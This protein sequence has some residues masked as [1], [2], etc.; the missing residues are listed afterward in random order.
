MSN[1]LNKKRNFAD[2][3]VITG[4]TYAGIQALPYVTAAVKSPD[5]VAKNYIRTIDGLTKS[6]VVNN[7][8]TTASGG[9]GIIQPGGT[10][11]AC[12]FNAGDNLETTEQV[13]TLIDLKVQEQICRATVFPTWMGQGMD[14]NGDLPNSFSDFL[15]STVAGAAGQMLE[16]SIWLGKFDQTNNSVG[17]VSNDGV[18]DQTGLDASA[19]KDFA[20]VE[21]LGAETGAGTLTFFEDVFK[22]TAETV[23][24]IMSKP[25]FGFYVGNQIYSLYLSG[26]AQAGGNGMGNMVTNQAINMP[27]YLGYPVYL[28]PGMPSKCIVA[29]YKDNLIFGSNLATDYTEAQLIPTYQYDGSDNV[30]I[31]MKFAVGV[32]VGVAT[33]GVVGKNLV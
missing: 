5:T 28:C 26:L 22:K 4:D 31:G 8:G 7:V 6:A 27:T 20:Q 3:I 21:T 15:L 11:A 18:F 2:D 16:N 23:P 25:G 17:F 24:G 14:R 33:D 12:S 1:K 9:T 30:R 13:L 10:G 32:Q 29:T 19:C